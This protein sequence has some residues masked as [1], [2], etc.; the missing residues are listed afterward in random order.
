MGVPLAPI[1]ALWMVLTDLIPQVGGFLGG[2][3]LH[4][5]AVSQSVTVGLVC[6][7]LYLIYMNLEN[8]VISP[9]IV[10][11]AVDAVAADHDAGRARRRRGGWHSRRTV[12]HAARRAR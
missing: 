11:Q 6:L 12:R 3:V 4:V 7:I 8:H 9:V 1:A 10:G 5:L 2:G